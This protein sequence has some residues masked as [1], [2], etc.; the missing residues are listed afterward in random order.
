[1]F[2]IC[3]G[4]VFPSRPVC[5]RWRRLKPCSGYSL[6]RH[7]PQSRVLAPTAHHKC[8]I[9]PF[10]ATPANLIS[11]NLVSLVELCS[12]GVRRRRRRSNKN[13]TNTRA[14]PGSVQTPREHTRHARNIPRGALFENLSRVGHHSRPT[15]GRYGSTVAK[16]TPNL[17]TVGQLCRVL[18]D[19]DLHRSNYGRT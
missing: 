17:T 11:Y 13:Q 7:T 2:V 10:C 19:I 12:R 15:F 1:M 3:L 18:P 16:V 4:V 5:R 8:G 14:P 9:A 6:E